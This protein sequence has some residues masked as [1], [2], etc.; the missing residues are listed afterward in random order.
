MNISVKVES[1]DDLTDIIQMLRTEDIRISDLE[2]G[3]DAHDE[4]SAFICLSLKE[5][6]THTE[7][8]TMLAASHGIIS[9]N[10]T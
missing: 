1:A 10:E 5:R 3:K 8:L 2:I 9:I 6:R 4:I 7:I